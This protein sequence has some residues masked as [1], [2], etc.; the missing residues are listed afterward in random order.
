M[1]IKLA[2]TCFALDLNATHEWKEESRIDIL[3]LTV[4]Q[5][6]TSTTGRTQ[7]LHVLM[8]VFSQ[9]S[10][11]LFFSDRGSSWATSY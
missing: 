2:Q 6:V 5:T 8:L 9:R 7:F 3:W 4:S 10:I 1:R 11:R